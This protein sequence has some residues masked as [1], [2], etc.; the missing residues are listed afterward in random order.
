MKAILW[1][2]LKVDFS[3]LTKMPKEHQ[4]KFEGLG[5]VC[6]VS[7]LSE[8]VEGRLPFIHLQIGT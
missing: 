4:N 7:F 3:F 5:N 2:E 8:V 6:G 1:A